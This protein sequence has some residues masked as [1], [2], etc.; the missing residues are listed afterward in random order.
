[1]HLYCYQ[2][3]RLYTSGHTGVSSTNHKSRLHTIDQS[4]VLS[5]RR[6]AR[7]AGD[8]RVGGAH[9]VVRT[10]ST[11]G[12][13]VTRIQD[14]YEQTVLLE[15][16]CNSCVTNGK[17]ADCATRFSPY[18]VGGGPGGCSA[19]AHTP[20]GTRPSLIERGGYLLYITLAVTLL[21]VLTAPGG[22]SSHRQERERKRD[23]DS[24]SGICVRLH[25][26]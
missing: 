24:V 13:G 20:R 21:N 6:A 18:L 9:L 17:V 16:L 26:Q 19:W 8:I 15:R 25:N 14:S 10:R 5:A 12:Q 4:Q 2:H 23:R 1:M 22:E 7:S 3:T 11:F